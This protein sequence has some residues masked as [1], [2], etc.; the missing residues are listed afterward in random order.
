MPRD[1]LYDLPSRRSTAVSVN[2][3]DLATEKIYLLRAQAAKAEWESEVPQDEHTSVSK[4]YSWGGL[5]HILNQ[6]L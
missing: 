5:Y 2:H 3:A 4:F 1:T 6:P